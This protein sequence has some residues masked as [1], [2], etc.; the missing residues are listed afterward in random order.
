M[1]TFLILF[2]AVYY[3]GDLFFDVTY[4]LCGIYYHTIFITYMITC[5][6]AIFACSVCFITLI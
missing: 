6:D 1:L 4:V 3:L 5:Y 2:Y